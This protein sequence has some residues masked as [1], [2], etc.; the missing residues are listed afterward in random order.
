MLDGRIDI[1]GSIKDLKREGQLQDIVLHAKAEEAEVPAPEAD[2]VLKEAEGAPVVTPAVADADAAQRRPKK[3]V[4]DEARAE[5]SVKWE[6]YK[7]YISASS[8]FVWAAVL[9]LILVGQCLFVAERLWMK[10]WGEV[11]F[12]SRPVSGWH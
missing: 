9:F 6:V 8:Y 1:S 10:T 2:L 5:G 4:K 11:S 3:L 7:A 12:S